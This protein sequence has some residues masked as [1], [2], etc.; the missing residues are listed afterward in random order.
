M[1]SFLFVYFIL[2]SIVNYCQTNK[3][4]P[5]PTEKIQSIIN[6][7]IDNKVIFGSVFTISKG[8]ETITLSAGNLS[9]NSQYFIASVTKLYENSSSKCNLRT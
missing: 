8:N 9:T 1:K 3:Q 2:F 6:S 4:K 7:S 5:I